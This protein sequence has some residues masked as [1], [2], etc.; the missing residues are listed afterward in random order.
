MR[1]DD[2]KGVKR[3]LRDPCEIVPTCPFCQ[4]GPFRFARRMKNMDICVCEFCGTRMSVPY[5]AWKKRLDG[6]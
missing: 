6:T 2:D 3:E 5:E 4:S 1:A